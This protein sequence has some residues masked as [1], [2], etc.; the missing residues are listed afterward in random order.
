M[1]KSSVEAVCALFASLG[2][3]EKVSTSFWKIPPKTFDLSIQR[4][5]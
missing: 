5:A 2:D 1:S 4:G 3:D